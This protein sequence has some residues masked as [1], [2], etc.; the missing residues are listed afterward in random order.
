[1]VLPIGFTAGRVLSGDQ[2]VEW[3]WA[4]SRTTTF[5]S[6]TNGSDVNLGT[7]DDGFFW[8]DGSSKSVRWQPI[9]IDGIGNVSFG[10]PQFLFNSNQSIPYGVKGEC[11]SHWACIWDLWVDQARVYNRANVGDNWSLVGTYNTSSI[12]SGLGAVRCFTNPDDPSQGN[13]II[14]EHWR[15]N[16]TGRVWLYKSGSVTT[17]NIGFGSEPSALGGN[18]LFIAGMDA[19]SNAYGTESGDA[20]MYKIGSTPFVGSSQTTTDT[21]FNPDLG[22]NDRFG[23]NDPGNDYGA[24]NLQNV[25]MAFGHTNARMYFFEIDDNGNAGNYTA[26]RNVGN[27]KY[28]YVTQPL[29]SFGTNHYFRYSA[30]YS[31]TVYHQILKYD[32]ST[33]S[34]GVHKTITGTDSNKDYV[35]NNSDYYAGYSSLS[36]TMRVWTLG[37]EIHVARS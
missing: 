24:I 27:Y 37:N 14:S 8:L 28:Q 31:T 29:N 9:T 7:Y 22:S 16:T 33:K 15:S 19:K 34:A 1:M 17:H 3:T 5:S 6:F 21:T 32:A 18:G 4:S 10:T 35:T 30:R 12:T 11:S 20:R 23:Y 25:M 2:A 26:S 13:A 36:Q